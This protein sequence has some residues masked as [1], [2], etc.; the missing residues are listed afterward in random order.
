MNLS[1]LIDRRKTIHR[2][3]M[4]TTAASEETHLF[5]GGTGYQLATICAKIRRVECASFDGK[6]IVPDWNL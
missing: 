4:P 5:G 2:S 6:T 3:S 1:F